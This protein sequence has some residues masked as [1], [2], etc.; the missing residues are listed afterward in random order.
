MACG[1]DHR[2]NNA[3]F[4][5]PVLRAPVAGVRMLPPDKSIHSVV[6]RGQRTRGGAVSIF[7]LT[8]EA[9]E[10]DLQ[11]ALREMHKLPILKAR[12]VFIRMEEGFLNAEQYGVVVIKL[13]NL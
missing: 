5:L 4:C 8:N 6:Q 11:K 1:I 9:C 13:I 3:H 7:M 10:S 2:F 12:T